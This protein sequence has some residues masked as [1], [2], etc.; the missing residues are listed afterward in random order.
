MNDTLTSLLQDNQKSPLQRSVE[1][2]QRC[3]FYT[4]IDE[5][6]QKLNELK[7]TDRKTC[8][9][10]LKFSSQRRGSGSGNLRAYQIKN[11]YKKFSRVVSSSDHAP[12]WESWM[13]FM[14]SDWHEQAAPPPNRILDIGCD[15][16]LSTIFL[17]TLYP[18]SHVV[19]IDPLP[20]GILQA[21]RLQKELGIPNVEFLQTTLEDL[22][23]SSTIHPFD[24]ANSI[25]GMS[26]KLL[27]FARESSEIFLSPEEID[28]FVYPKE[29]LAQEPAR[30]LKELLT[31]EGKALVIDRIP[32]I[33]SVHKVVN[34]FQMFGL[35]CTEAKF[36]AFENDNEDGRNRE[37]FPALQFKHAE[38]CPLL[39]FSETLHLARPYLEDGLQEGFP[40]AHELT[41]ERWH[42]AAQ[43]DLVVGYAFEG[44]E[45]QRCSFVELYKSPTMVI[46]FNWSFSGEF[47]SSQGP[48]DDLGK[49][50]DEIEIT[51]I[52]KATENEAIEFKTKEERAEVMDRLAT[53]G[54]DTASS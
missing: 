3:G 21:E 30:S 31:P 16:G 23:T 41:R 35:G 29:S 26:D 9:Q 18:D 11:S 1:F 47:K 43:M 53:R 17:A 37:V 38:P 10:F 15:V 49:N 8:N 14:L 48:P 36:I 51:T 7:E 6:C 25:T 42:M 44:K 28:S 32:S 13:S 45:P 20:E 52:L 39:T 27:L 54:A 34:A 24:L 19:G 40:T 5:I 12:I 4:D 2:I 33:N 46:R 50:L 22:P